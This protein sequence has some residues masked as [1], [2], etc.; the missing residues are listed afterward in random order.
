M[1][2]IDKT[3]PKID[4]EKEAEQFTLK[5]LFIKKALREM[6]AN[7]DDELIKSTLKIGLSALEGR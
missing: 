4:W 6:E 1:K 2:I 3:T 7:E 5:G